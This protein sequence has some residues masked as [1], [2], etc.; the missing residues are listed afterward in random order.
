MTQSLQVVRP[1]ERD[2]GTAQTPGMERL[3][4]IASG[5]VGAQGLWVGYVT[6]GPGIRSGAH[7]HGNVESGIYIIRGRARLRFGPALEQSIDA[8][9]G[10]FVYVPPEAVHQEINL[11][12]AEPIEMIVARNAQE[13]VVVNVEL[14]EA[15]TG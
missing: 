6:M 5:T 10:D 13:N 11:D 2:P 14:P 1:H 15:V 3:A 4:G 7:H 9:P 12:D 8:G